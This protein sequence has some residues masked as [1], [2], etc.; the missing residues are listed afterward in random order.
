MDW[1]GN[2]YIIFVRCPTGMRSRR[3]QYDIQQTL[4]KAGCEAV[5]GINLSGPGPCERGNYL[6]GC[7]KRGKRLDSFGNL[8]RP[9]WFSAAG[10]RRLN[11]TFL[12]KKAILHIFYV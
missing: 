2:R 8:L 7:I 3:R 11:L 5:C 10:N 6:P 4:S 12:A 1:V 9:E